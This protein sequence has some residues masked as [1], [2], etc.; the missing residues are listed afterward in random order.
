MDL[1]GLGHFDVL[2]A[3]L[4][5]GH[6]IKLKVKA[7]NGPSHGQPCLWERGLG[8]LSPSDAPPKKHSSLPKLSTLATEIIPLD[9]CELSLNEL[10]NLQ[11]DTNRE[12]FSGYA[13]FFVKICAKIA[14]KGNVIWGVL[15]PSA[16]IVRSAS[17]PR[18]KYRW[19]LTGVPP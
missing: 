13:K 10:P 19:E 4:I 17:R 14:S 3:S 2:N 15:V 9:F 1:G 7:P 6:R 8:I 18:S 11:E 12:T 16:K 5:S